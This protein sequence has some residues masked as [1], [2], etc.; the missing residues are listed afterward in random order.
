MSSGWMCCWQA[1]CATDLWESS[2]LTVGVSPLP[3]L[4]GS[5]AMGPV[6]EWWG[7]SAVWVLPLSAE[8]LIHRTPLPNP[9]S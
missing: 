5:W 1:H 7:W 8:P 4:W 3:V 2:G 6:V 9:L